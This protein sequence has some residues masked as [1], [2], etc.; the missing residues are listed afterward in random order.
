MRVLYTG[1]VNTVNDTLA[2]YKYLLR[3]VYDELLSRANSCDACDD[4]IQIKIKMDR[5]AQ[6]LE[7][8]LLV[9]VKAN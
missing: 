6:E 4:V 2:S 1:I 5:I 8:R 9:D 3:I 7:I